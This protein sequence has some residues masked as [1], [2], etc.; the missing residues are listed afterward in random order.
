MCWYDRLEEGREINLVQ[1]TPSPISIYQSTSKRRC[2]Q[3]SSTLSCQMQYMLMLL[4]YALFR[5]YHRYLIHFTKN[6]AMNHLPASALK[7]QRDE[8]DIH[9]DFRYPISPTLLAFLFPWSLI[10]VP[11]LPSSRISANA[12]LLGATP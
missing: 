9:T 8:K 6:A 1:R 11:S 4:I 5:C 7:H 10:P 12:F 3:S 2:Y